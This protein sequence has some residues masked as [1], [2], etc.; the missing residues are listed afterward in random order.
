VEYGRRKR[1]Q[2]NGKTRIICRI[3]KEGDKLDYH[4]YRGISLLSTMYKICTNIIKMRLETYSENM[5]GEYQ[6]GFRRERSVTDQLFTF[7]QLLEKFWE[8]DIDLYK[9]FVDF[10]QAE[11]STKREKLYT[12]MQEM[13]IPDKLIRLERSTVTETRAQVRTQG[14]LTGE[15][16]VKQ[17]CKQGDGLAPILFNLGLECIVRKLTV[18]T[19]STLL[20]KQVQIVGYADDINIMPRTSKAA[21]ET[22]EE[23]TWK[24]MR[25]GS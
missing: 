4:N 8:H 17:G 24:P 10:K 20:Y 7:K 23:L 14:R 19:N 5:I 21:K 11:D 2:W 9:I 18:I 3:Y 25:Q 22:S 15:F 13:G 1:Y 12:V 16:E 6:A